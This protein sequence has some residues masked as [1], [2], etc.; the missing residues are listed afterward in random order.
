MQATE[1][2]KGTAIIFEKE[3]YIVTDY[4]HRTPGNLRSFVQASLKNVHSA[5]IIQ[6]RFA[7]GDSIVRVILE[8]KQ[9][10]FLYKDDQ[11]FHF[12]DMESYHSFPL[13]EDV[14]GDGKNYL[15]ENMELKILFHE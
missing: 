11:G 4:A 8:P 9:C 2:R 1:L 5:Y 3:L 13:G 10:Q 15:K 14:I 12:M 7:S 6:N